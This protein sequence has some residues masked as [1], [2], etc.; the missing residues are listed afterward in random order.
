MPPDD[1]P[2]RNEPRPSDFDRRAREAARRIL[3]RLE[4]LYVEHPSDDL[5][6]SIEELRTLQEEM[7]DMERGG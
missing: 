6:A 3:R 7:E 5:R 2:D 1:E 4:A